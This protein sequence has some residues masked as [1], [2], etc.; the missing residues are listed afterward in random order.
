[1]RKVCVNLETMRTYVIKRRH[2]DFGGMRGMPEGNPGAEITALGTIL[3]GM[4][5]K[6]GKESMYSRRIVGRTHII[7]DT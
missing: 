3:A 7:N 2:E 5:N 6:E 4:Y 1:M